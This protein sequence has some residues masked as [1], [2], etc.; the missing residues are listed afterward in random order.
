[1]LQR[2]WAIARILAA[3]IARCI[4]AFQEHSI[5]TPQFLTKTVF[6]L[7]LSSSHS[8]AIRPFILLID[9]NASGGMQRDWTVQRGPGRQMGAVCTLLN[10]RL[11]Q[12]SEPQ[13]CRGDGLHRCV[14]KPRA[15]GS[16]VSLHRRSSARAYLFI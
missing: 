12:T 10:A 3:E 14:L 8:C 9:L 2:K 5:E 1:M 11:I 7:S 15:A 6:H 4:I 13:P 16:F